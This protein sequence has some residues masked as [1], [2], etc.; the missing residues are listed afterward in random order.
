M[1]SPDSLYAKLTTTDSAM[2]Y[3]MEVHCSGAVVC[4]PVSGL[5]WVSI[6]KCGVSSAFGRKE[7]FCQMEQ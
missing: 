7:N 4:D 6:I 5:P 1:L 3:P 2:V